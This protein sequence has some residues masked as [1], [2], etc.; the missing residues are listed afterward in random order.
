MIGENDMAAKKKP[1]SAPPTKRNSA[2]IEAREGETV[3]KAKA[4]IVVNPTFNAAIVE[5]KIIGGIVSG[6][7]LSLTDIHTALIEKFRP[8]VR[9]NDMSSVEAML[10]AQAHTCD[11]IFNDYALKAMVSDTMPKLEAYMRMALKAQQQSASTLRVL[12]ELKSPKQIAFIKQANV[13]HQQQ[14][15]NGTAPPVARAH[16]ESSNQSNELLGHH[17]GE[18]MDTG[19][20]GQASRGNQALETVGTI[21]RA[22]D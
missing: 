16:E 15:N 1:A 17:H 13:S 2:T 7:N 22:K 19:A 11:L 8:V 3:S 9:E 12:G 20:T 14:V 21:D 4:R 5:R 10:L 6:I 18:R